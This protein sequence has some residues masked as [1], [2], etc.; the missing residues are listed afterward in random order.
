M[1]KDSTAAEEFMKRGRIDYIDEQDLD[2]IRG[3]T[4]KILS[5][6]YRNLKNLGCEDLPEVEEQFQII[7]NRVVNLTEQVKSLQRK[8]SEKVNPANA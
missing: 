2:I 6:V 7:E 4:H 8:I 1:E 3:D 5:G